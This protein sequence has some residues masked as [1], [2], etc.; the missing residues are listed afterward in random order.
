MLYGEGG[1]GREK[2]VQKRFTLCRNNEVL[3][4]AV[5]VGWAAEV[6]WLVAACI[7]EGALPPVRG[8]E[9]PA[10][11]PAC[12]GCEDRAGQGKQKT[13]KRPVMLM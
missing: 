5:W 7:G 11:L 12:L 2:A 4:K 13:L 6:V 10:R 9:G 8:R 1:G 3:E